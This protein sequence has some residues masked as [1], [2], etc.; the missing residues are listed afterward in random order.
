MGVQS[1]QE[2]VTSVLAGR[3]EE[4]AVLATRY[5]RLVRSVVLARLHDRHAAEDVAQE[6]FLAAFE[7]LNSLRQPER[8]GGWLLAIAKFQAGRYLR[9]SLTRATTN[10]AIDATELGDAKRQAV[11]SP[12]GEL[13]ELVQQ[14]PDHERV[15][16]GLRHFSEH[17]V[18]DIADIT[19]R[20]VGTVT[21]QLSRAYERL[22]RW[23]KMEVRS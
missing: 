13:L 16:V 7:K 9:D 17:S 14:L 19:G 23:M 22:K 6:A 5:E 10:D 18:Q 15:V 21:K 2:L 3:T 11:D 12:F 8:F 1:D 4:F 20:P